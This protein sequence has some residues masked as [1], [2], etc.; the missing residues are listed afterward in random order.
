MIDHL[1]MTLTFHA[2]IDLTIKA[3][4]R[5]SFAGKKALPIDASKRSR[6]SRL[7]KS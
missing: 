3:R 5:T 4:T 7:L 2:E 1:I 6:I